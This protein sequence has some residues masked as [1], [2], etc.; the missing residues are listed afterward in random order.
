MSTHE[1]FNIVYSKKKKFSLQLDKL[2]YDC[3]ENVHLIAMI[4]PYNAHLLLMQ[5]NH[6]FFS[7]QLR[8]IPHLHH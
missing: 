1:L 6:C 4:A 2:Y 8:V 3:G 7:F 5:L